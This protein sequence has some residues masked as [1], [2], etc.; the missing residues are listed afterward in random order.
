MRRPILLAALLASTSLHVAHAGIRMHGQAV[1]NAC[2]GQPAGVVG[3]G[4]CNV[5]ISKSTNGARGATVN[6]S[7]YP[8]LPAGFSYS[9]STKNSNINGTGTT[10][11]SIDNLLQGGFYYSGN[12]T[13]TLTDFTLTSNS[14]VTLS[15]FNLGTGTTST[16]ITG[17]TN[18]DGEHGTIDGAL[19]DASLTTMIQAHGTGTFKLAFTNV[20][21]PSRDPYTIDGL[22]GITV[23][24]QDYFNAYAQ[25]TNFGDHNE[26]LH[27]FSCVTGSAVTRT[28]FNMAD[29]NPRLDTTAGGFQIQTG[30]GDDPTTYSGGSCTINFAANVIRYGS[31]VNASIW[32]LKAVFAD[33]TVNIGAQNGL[34]GNVWD[35]AATAPTTGIVQQADLTVTSVVGTFTVGGETVATVGNVKTAPS[36]GGV[37]SG[38]NIHLLT[39]GTGLPFAPGDALIGQTSGATALVTAVA[40]H[41]VTVNNLGGNVDFN[42][43]PVNP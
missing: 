19:S 43:N 1:S 12:G 11:P 16:T 10:V 32:S 39:Y 5:A 2:T 22:G 20:L 42:N 6:V 35:V 26:W 37:T 36:Q 30:L 15:G 40:Y 4:L 29:G 8:S 27:L 18:F 14:G 31:V 23:L 9:S 41:K 3:N 7:V 21:N 33:I 38:T 34:P 28:F 24:D 13:H 17:N 25:N